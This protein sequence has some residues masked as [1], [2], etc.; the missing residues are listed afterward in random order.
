MKVTNNQAG[1]RGLN[2]LDGAVLVDPGQTVDVDMADAEMKVAK[3][4][5]W[6][7]FGAAKAADEGSLDREDLKKQA[8]E[9]GIEYARN[10]PTDKLKE[11]V[12]A[13]LAE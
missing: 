6:F 9:L 5:G 1:P 3:A 10:I 12:D 8:D 2:T 13:K 11:L 4:T 7:S